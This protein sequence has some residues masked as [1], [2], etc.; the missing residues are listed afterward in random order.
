MCLVG[1]ISGR[2]GVGGGA[3]AASSACGVRGTG[4]DVDSG[5]SGEQDAPA[6]ATLALF[7]CV[8]PLTLPAPV[9][10]AL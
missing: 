5:V 7:P 9:M 4:A 2:A 10:L 3:C 8:F 1:F 6:T